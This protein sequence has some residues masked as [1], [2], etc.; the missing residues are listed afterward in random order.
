MDCGSVQIQLLGRF[1]IRSGESG[2]QLVSVPSRRRRAL[3]GYLAMQPGYSETRERLAT[4]LWGDVPDRQARQSLRQAL[5]AMRADFAPLGPEPLR[6]ERDSIGLDPDLIKVDARDLLALADSERPEDIQ[7]AASLYTGPFLDG[8]DL[9]AEGFSDW[10]AHQRHRMNVAATT[11]FARA[12]EQAA[13]AENGALALHFAERLLALDPSRSSSHYLLLRVVARHRGRDQALADADRIGRMLRDD[14]GVGLDARTRA[15]I[16]DIKSDTGGTIQ[17][18]QMPPVLQQNPPISPE[19]ES[20]ERRSATA[21]TVADRP[22]LPFARPRY[23]AAQI[24]LGIA[25]L[26][27]AA[28]ALGR[29]VDW[30]R[31]RTAGENQNA[32]DTGAS[33]APLV[34][35]PS[36]AIANLSTQGL[37]PIMVL[38]FL[39]SSDA[40]AT[41]DA[42]VADL[43]TDDLI[44]DLS[45][46]STLRVISRSTSRLFKGKTFD[47]AMIG[48]EL[49]VRYVV[50]GSVQIADGV[51]R[52]DAALTDTSSRLNLWAQRF[53]RPIAEL[54]AVKSEITRS[55]A[56]QLQVT[57]R[58]A[59]DARLVPKPSDDPTLEDLLTRGWAAMVRSPGEGPSASAASFFEAALKRA[60]DNLS[61]QLGYAGSQIVPATTVF[62]R[63]SEF[64]LDRADAMLKAVLG[65]A[66]RHSTALLYR[67]MLRRLRGDFTGARDDFVSAIES[68]PSFATAYGQ[69]GQTFYRLGDYDRGLEFI[70]YAIR[71]SPRDPGLGVWSYMAG[72]I[73]IE[74]GNDAAAFEWLNRSATLIP[75]GIYTRLGLAAILVHRGDT[76][77]AVDQIRELSRIAPWLNFETVRSG[78]GTYEPKWARQRL[79]D[80]LEKAFASAAQQGVADSGPK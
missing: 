9:P 15:L 61:A 40:N 74:R 76:A 28:V 66:S 30:A 39:S 73:E 80:G 75:R 67:G 59:E 6:V 58:L 50:G 56:R 42:R 31:L 37:D 65:R 62:G 71:L 49:G 78:L 33:R 47:I 22:T 57:I 14:L 38:P 19:R 45:T 52:I 55:I 70:R 32:A 2:H 12:A 7:R 69:A 64:D 18:K 5:A 54:N 17:G 35:G 27:V 10:L 43:L 44:N 51:A 36:A 3:L 21:A 20:T 72:M 53:E 29:T 4:L 34:H 26:A 13:A 25:V 79:M 48:T 46:V 23:R 1:S 63:S 16:A 68:S 41:E 24:V 11:V 60:P 77:A 8:I